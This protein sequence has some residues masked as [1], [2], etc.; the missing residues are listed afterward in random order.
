[1]IV[2]MSGAA[3]KESADVQTAV[4]SHRPG[5]TVTVVVHRDGE[6]VTL[7]ATLSERPNDS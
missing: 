7:D 1:M 2:E 3:I 4:R 6:R 5:D